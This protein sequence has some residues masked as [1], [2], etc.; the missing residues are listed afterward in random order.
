MD[1]EKESDNKKEERKKKWVKEKIHK[2]IDKLKE[3]KIQ[4]K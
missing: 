3:R 4:S 2:P 1:I